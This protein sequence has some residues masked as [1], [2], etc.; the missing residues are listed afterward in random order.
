MESV[1]TVDMLLLKYRY[2]VPVHTVPYRYLINGTVQV[3]ISGTGLY[4]YS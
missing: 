2:P 4:S 3:K 1:I